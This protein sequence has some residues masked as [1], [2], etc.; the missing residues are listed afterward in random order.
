MQL[1]VVLSIQILHI[2]LSIPPS[3][4]YVQGTS[5]AKISRE[6]NYT[7]R[8]ASIPNLIV[9]PSVPVPYI[10]IRNSQNKCL[11]NAVSACT[12]SWYQRWQIRSYNNSKT[13]FNVVN[14]QTG[15]CLAV[16]KNP[17]NIQVGTVACLFP[18]DLGNLILWNAV[19]NN[20][21][22]STW[23]LVS[24]QN[25]GYL[26]FSGTTPIWQTSSGAAIQRWQFFSIPSPTG[27]L[28][29]WSTP[30]QLPLVGIAAANLADGRV[31]L[32][33][34]AQVDN[35]ATGELR[36]YA[37]F[38]DPT[39]GEASLRLITS[40]QADM[41]CPGTAL[42]ADGTVMVVGGV[43]AGV[44]NSFNGTTW[45]KSARLNIPRGYNSAVTLSDGRV[46][47]LGGSWSGGHGGKSGEVFTPGLGWRLLSQIKADP[48][49]TEDAG[50]IYRQD[51]HMWLFAAAGGWVFHA[52]PS[53]AMHWVSVA[54]NGV[55][56]AAGNRS[57][58]GHAMNGDA[59]L[60]DVGKILT[61]GGAPNYAGGVPTANAYVIDISAGPG[62]NVTVRRTGSLCTARALHTAVVLPNGE[63]VVIG[64]QTGQ[65]TLFQDSAAVM[66]AEIWSP[67]TERFSA[68]AW[69]PG[70]MPMA[71]PRAYH[72]VA[73]L[74]A[75]GRVLSSGGGGC[76][77]LCMYNH[78]DAQIL[79]PPYLLNP[80]GTPATRPTLLAAPTAVAPG[81]TVQVTAAG[82]A[83]FV[84]V[85]LGSSTHTVNTDQRRVPLAATL[86]PA[87]AGGDGTS[88]AACYALTLPADPGV[89]VPGDYFLFALG[90]TGTPSV[91]RVLFV[92]V[93][94][95]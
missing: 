66:T 78:L 2:S 73:L 39:T 30:I 44:T 74:L 69:A 95:R 90:P 88:G 81:S 8:T 29:Q 86:L 56:L 85:R 33:S 13:Q 55:V 49:L 93:A 92:G 45:A 42:L 19:F 14:L 83:S 51:N 4:K 48:F 72:S 36:T 89:V 20:D 28:S 11:Y 65:T 77:L 68:L 7:V 67:V 71:T 1:R 60:Y 54:G 35:Y 76:G 58:D 79:T 21:A 27:R 6:F 61:V 3:I 84:L 87:A 22:A 41:F 37:A 12:G 15:L 23:S 52:G 62:G 17:S 80:D 25:G 40:L 64:G 91:A 70:A 32:W 75:D 53:K 50:G 31:L 24:V 94:K 47:T 46:F 16:N 18:Q 5:H 26:T 63:V 34:S 10:E 57:D 38:Y 43:T 9:D 59:V 82:A